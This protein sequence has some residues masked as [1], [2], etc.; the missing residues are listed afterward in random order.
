MY[1][2]IKCINDLNEL[3]RI[4]VNMKCEQVNYLLQRWI[5]SWPLSVGRPLSHGQQLFEHPAKIDVDY[6]L[7]PLPPVSNLIS[8]TQLILSNYFGDESRRMKRWTN[9]ADRSVV[10]GYYWPCNLSK[11]CQIQVRFEEVILILRNS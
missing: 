6:T 5:S 1:N 7:A 3:N 11:R 9:A 4:W 8:Q 2:L 10:P